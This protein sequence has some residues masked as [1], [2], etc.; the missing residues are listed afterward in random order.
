[1]IVASFIARFVV[2]LFA[3]Q[4][5]FGYETQM[6]HHSQMQDERKMEGI[7]EAVESVLLETNIS[8]QDKMLRV[9]YKIRNKTA[10]PIYLFNVLWDTTS[11]GQYVAAPQAVYSCLRGDE[12]FHIAKQ[13]LPLP[14][15]KRVELRIVPFVTKVEAG[16]DF[17][18]R[19]ELEVPAPE[20]NP[21]FPMM[22][23]SGEERKMAQAVVFSIQYVAE[24]EGLEVKPAPLGAALNIW[25]QNLV[26]SIRALSSKP[27]SIS[28]P[29][30][31]R[32]D[33]FEE[34]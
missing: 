29:V 7:S 27:K 8:L 12:T 20:Y 24:I 34:F 17:I 26:G 2:L 32:T 16:A 25:H 14:K 23:D 30:K 5:M 10:K 28:F 9:E 13:I 3:A 4:S 6:F 22:K 11:S 31:K 21:Y 19:F 18:D 33:Y 15:N 1:M